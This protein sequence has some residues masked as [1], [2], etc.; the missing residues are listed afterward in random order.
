MAKND[1][2][3]RPSYHSRL[4]FNVVDPEEVMRLSQLDPQ[5]KTAFRCMHSLFYDLPDGRSLLMLSGAVDINLRSPGWTNEAAQTAPYQEKIELEIA[6]PADFM[7]EGQHFSIEQSLPYAGLGS[8][9]GTANVLWGLNHFTIDVENPARRSVT[10]K[11]E[12]EVAR[13]AEVLRTISFS[14]TLLGRRC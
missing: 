9:A 4:R 10:L 13:S 6:L 7:D 3:Y 5:N 12:A 1:E 8:L 11:L 2:F 14:I